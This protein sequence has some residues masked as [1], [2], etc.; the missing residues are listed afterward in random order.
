LPEVLEPPHPMPMAIA[1][2]IPAQA[3]EALMHPPP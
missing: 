3:L 2:Q 1:R